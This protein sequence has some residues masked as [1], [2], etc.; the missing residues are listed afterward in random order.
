MAGGTMVAMVWE[1]AMEAAMEAA[2]RAK[3]TRHRHRTAIGSHCG[4]LKPR[5]CSAGMCSQQHPQSDC[6][7]RC[8][9]LAV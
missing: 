3:R 2:A 7:R 6:G 4:P 9:N 8:L 1:A 5:N